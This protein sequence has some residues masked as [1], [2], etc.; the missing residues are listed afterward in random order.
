[1]RLLQLDKAGVITLTEDFI[2][3]VPPYAILSHTWGNDGDEVLFA[4]LTNGQGKQKPGY[5]KLQFCADRAT[6]D[7]LNYFWVDTCCIDKKSSAELAEAINSMFHWY[8][9]AAKCYVYLV[10]VALGETETTN[11]AFDS[12]GPSFRESRWYTRGWTLQELLAPS[13]V[14]FFSMEGT[15]L[16]DKSSLKVQ[17]HEITGI[18]I[19]ALEGRSPLSYSI[20]ERF[21]WAE[22]RRTKRQEDKAYSLLGL[23]GVHMPLLY[24]EGFQSAFH[25]LCETVNRLPKYPPIGE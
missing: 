25:R 22:H 23:F 4:D 19:D 1:M 21:K 7:G 9:R 16:G 3:A 2:D 24:G 8:Q 14:E 12:W 13:H 18:P 6:L 15:L 5:R 10:D 11:Q 17:I 20:I